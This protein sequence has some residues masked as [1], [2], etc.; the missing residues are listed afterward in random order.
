MKKRSSL[1]TCVGFCTVFSMLSFCSTGGKSEPV[2]MEIASVKGSLETGEMLVILVEAGGD[3]LLPISIGSDQALAIHL[4]HRHII[5]PRPMTHD[6]MATMLKTLDSTV[7]RVI[8]SDLREGTYYAEIVLRTHGEE[9]KIDARPSDA[10]A[11]SLRVEAPIYSMPHLLE[12]IHGLESTPVLPA[13]ATI[14]GWGFTV[15]AMTAKLADFF[16]TDN[17]VLVADVRPDS[18]ADTAGLLPGDVIL[19]VNNSEVANVKSMLRILASPEPSDRL[20]LDCQRQGEKRQVTI[21]KS[22]E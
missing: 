11:L 2:L 16:G 10:I 5:P 21:Q 20:V 17:G 12:R 13:P 6:L 7:D 3:R 15:Q 14:S 4:G 18:P 9:V 8:I 1:V 19:R 22:H